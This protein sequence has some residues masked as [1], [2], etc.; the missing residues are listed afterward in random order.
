[1]KKQTTEVKV[2]Y[3]IAVIILHLIIFLQVLPNMVITIGA[4]WGVTLPYAKVT[5]TII[6]AKI[7]Q[8][9]F[10]SPNSK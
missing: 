5:A 6:F 9:L 7:A 3:G 8:I 4:M 1:M 2:L 10:G